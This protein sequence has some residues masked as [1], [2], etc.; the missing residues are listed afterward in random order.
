MINYLLVMAISL[1]FFVIVAALSCRSIRL[2]SAVQ[3]VKLLL[4]PIS[5]FIWPML[6][7]AGDASRTSWHDMFFEYWIYISRKG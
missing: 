2:L 4:W 7:A 3:F 6:L 5:Y 1:W